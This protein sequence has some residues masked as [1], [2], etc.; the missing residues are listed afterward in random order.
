MST[1]RELEHAIENAKEYIQRRDLALKLSENFEFRKLIIED[2]MEKE[3]AR[4]VHQSGDPV[5]DPQMRA[6]ALAMAQAAGHLKRY[7]NVM[8]QMGNS[9]EDHLKDYEDELVA[10]RIEEDFDDE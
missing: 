1:V 3:A 4:L 9:A 2:F 6:D 5:L 7:L 10:A 8:I